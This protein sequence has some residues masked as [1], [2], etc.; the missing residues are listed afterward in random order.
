LSDT[1]TKLFSS[2]T[3]ST[4]WEEPY[5]T[6]I[7]WV[8]MLAM[9]DARGDVYSSVPG[10]ARRANVTRQ[11][12]E[13]A[14][15]SFLAPDS[16]SR[17]KE[18]EGRRIE[19]INGGWNLIN[20]AKYAAIRDAEERRAYMRE[21]MREYRTNHVNTVNNVNTPLA[22]LAELATPTPTPT[23]EEPK[24]EQTAQPRKRGTRLPEDW[25]PSSADLE[26]VR[27]TRPDLNQSMESEVAKFCDY[28]HAKPGKDGTKL[29]WSATWRNWIRNARANA[30][31]GPQQPPGKQVQAIHAIQRLRD[32]CRNDERPD[33]DP[34]AKADVHR[35]GG[36]A[37]R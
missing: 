2:I 5:S 8:T 4:V 9:A 32:E 14:L 16:D 10:L 37:V 22:D 15:A 12:V 35:L 6:R 7:T 27:K 26:F 1:Y 34:H 28:W 3:E 30:R 19:P 11:E 24:Q 18:H 13:A 31:A 20:H 36:P 21:Y 25:E 29:D 33:S 23:P 17:T